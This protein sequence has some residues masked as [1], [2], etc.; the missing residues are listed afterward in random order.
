M[1]IPYYFY[2]LTKSYKDIVSNKLL[3]KPNVY[4]L[5]FNGIIHPI[6]SKI[7]TKSTDEDYMIKKLY[8]KIDTDIKN[9][10]P[11]KTIICVDGVVPLAKMIQQRRRRYLT[12]YK[13][14]IDNVSVN[15]DTNAI[16]PGTKF[17]N[18]LNVFFQ[19]KVRYNTTDCDIIF[20]GSDDY[21]EGEH[22]IFKY[23]KIED[24][25]KVV[26][27]NG[28]DADLIILCLINHRKNMY[29]MRESETNTYV[30]IDNLRRAIL[31]EL[32]QKWN[33]PKQEDIYSEDAKDIIE[34][35]CVMCSLLGNDFIPHLLTLNMKDRGL[36]KLISFT[37]ESYKTYGL[38]VQKSNINYKGLTE[39]L[40]NIAKTEDK[41]IYAETEKY[42]KNKSENPVKSEFY[43]IKNK[44]I[45]AN[46]IY[47]D[48]SKWRQSYYKYIFNTNISIDSSILSSVCF[49]YVKG[50]YWTYNYYK[51]EKYENNWYYPY[52]YPPTVKDITNYMLGN[53]E[54][55]VKD[56]K[57]P[58][59]TQI[60]LLIVLPRESISLLNDE[61]KKYMEDRKN[62][63]YHLYPIQYK[64]NT[65]LKTHLWECI[66]VLPS[67][68]IEY[69]RNHIK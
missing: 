20:S 38:L 15:W 63:L 34:S 31:A 3:V 56:I 7:I 60:Q 33:V 27:I 17:M 67:I 36:E 37:G 6:T 68:D 62:G 28:L 69:I 8:E 66:P 23:L 58:I 14:N 16:T 24:Y 65:Y 45:V 22:K 64:I 19:N 40:R 46:K 13:N 51:S 2:T 52:G 44:D 39:I 49:H 26:L 12:K 9:L 35:Y 41:D 47:T 5:D 48:V 61:N 54:P 57:V 1:G 4:C 53:P 25:S 10:K 21:G 18:K 59:N 55:E 42:I 32:V 30:N 50:I 43:G 29:L 11:N